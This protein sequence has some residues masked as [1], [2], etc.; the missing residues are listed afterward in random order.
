MSSSMASFFVISIIYLSKSMNIPLS[1]NNFCCDASALSLSNNNRVDN[2]RDNFSCASCDNYRDTF[3]S[4]FCARHDIFYVLSFVTQQKSHCKHNKHY[5]FYIE[6]F[7]LSFALRSS[8]SIHKRIDVYICTTD[9]DAFA[10][11]VFESAL[12]VLLTFFSFS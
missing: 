8:Q 6:R 10:Y 11:L 12:A 1:F 7:D 5:N 9:Q 2:Q 4:S 3:S